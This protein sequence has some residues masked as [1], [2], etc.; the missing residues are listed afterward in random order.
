MHD[1]AA[2]KKALQ[3]G[4]YTCVLCY[5][6]KLTASTRR[7]VA[8]LLEWLEAGIHP[9]FCAA[10]KVVG[11]ATAYLYC[12]LGAKEVYGAV[13]S[14]PALQVLQEHGICAHWDALV[15]QIRNRQD[16]GPCPMEAAT[17]DCHTPEQALDAI[18]TTLARLKR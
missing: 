9:G 7:G 6:G 15:P 11:R 16:T 14:W 3:D 18:Q 5:K 10:D 17:A 4:S 8:P 12:L 13:M 1:L 2:A